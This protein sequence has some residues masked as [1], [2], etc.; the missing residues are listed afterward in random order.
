MEIADFAQDFRTDKVPEK[1]SAMITAAVAAVLL[2]WPA[3]AADANSPAPD[4]PNSPAA[5]SQGADNKDPNSLAVRERVGFNR[6]C[7]YIFANFVDKDGFV[8]YKSLKFKRVYMKALLIEMEQTDRDEY[9][10]WTKDEQMAFWINAYNIQKLWLIIN[11][12]PVES[13]RWS[14]FWDWLSPHDIRHI[15]KTVGGIP[16]Q[17]FI[18]M[19]EEFTFRAIEERLRTDFDE[20]RVFFAL[21]W[22]SRGGPPLRPEPYYGYR[23]DDQLDEQVRKY[24]S[25][26]RAFRIDRDKKRVEVSCLFGPDL[27]GKL[28]TQKY[29]TDLKFKD[30]PPDMRAVLNFICGY[31]SPAEKSF[32]ETESYSVEDITYDW[33]INDIGQRDR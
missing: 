25:S 26:P 10:S 28:F 27:Y 1:L 18:I 9:K 21:S 20:P 12:F 23:L 22:A 16:I 17:K 15:D 8:N 29:G 6:Q 11:N 13:T 7:E 19:D 32:L 33:T 5:A 30:H 3:F 31:I 4:E 14:R 24:L 2:A